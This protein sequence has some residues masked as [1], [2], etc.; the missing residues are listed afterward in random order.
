MHEDKEAEMLR[1]PLEIVVLKC[2]ILD[3][4]EPRAVLSLAMD[5]PDISNIERA[6]LLLKEV[7]FPVLVWF[8]FCLAMTLF[9]RE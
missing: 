8:F 7:R 4:G 9:F 5:P 3:I 1:C 6:I 2:K